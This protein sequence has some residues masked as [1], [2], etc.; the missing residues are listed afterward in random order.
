[1][2]TCSSN[3]KQHCP[4]VF[5][6]LSFK[7]SKSEK[8]NEYNMTNTLIVSINKTITFD[9]YLKKSNS[10]WISCLWFVSAFLT[11]ARISSPSEL[12]SSALS[13]CVPTKINGDSGT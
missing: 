7:M 1:M 8:L 4:V 12:R 2:P 6:R 10:A 5:Q 11:A 9:S 13:A 3:H